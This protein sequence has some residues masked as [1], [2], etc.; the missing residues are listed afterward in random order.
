MIRPISRAVCAACALLLTMAVASAAQTSNP[1]QTSPLADAQRL[2]DA[3]QYSQSV[4]LLRA[5]AAKSP[6]DPQIPILLGRCYYEL[7]DFNRAIETLEHG[8][9][10]APKDSQAHDWLGRA[11]GRKAEQEM[12]LTAYSFAR[13]TRHEFETAVQLQPSNLEAQRDLI[14]FDMNAPPVVGGGDEK[15]LHE[16]D[17][18]AQIDPVEADL[19]HA[20]F[21]ATKKRFNDADQLYQ[22]ILADPKRVGVCLEAADYY[23]DSGD[24]AHMSA[25][26]AAAAKLDPNDR[27]LGY[28]RGVS[29]VMSGQRPAEA[30][31]LLRAYLTSTPENSAM[32]SH[33]STLEWIGALYEKEGRNSE[34]AQEYKACLEIDPKNR[35]ARD[36]LHRVEKN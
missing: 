35:A 19:A 15:A 10:L 13:K 1:P 28:Y 34:A 30:E 32:P 18:L 36:G 7:G 26:V 24:A 9:A 12:F 20:E 11:Y 14:R 17:S 27:R 8:V 2:F 5:A 31:Q 6:D 21:F 3:G 25:A 4:D 22:K 33:A 23:R 16:I 29:D